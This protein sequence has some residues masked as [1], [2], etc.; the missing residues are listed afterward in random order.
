MEAKTRMQ[1][2]VIQSRNGKVLKN[3]NRH[4]GEED[5]LYY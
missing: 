2:Y 3:A 5:I 4:L 1:I